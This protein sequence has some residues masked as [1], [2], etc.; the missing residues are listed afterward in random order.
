MNSLLIGTTNPAKLADYKQLLK[1]YR[2]KIISLA[3][4]KVVPPE[5]IG[6]TFEENAELKARYYYS[7]TGIPT[8]ADDGGFEIEALNGEPGVRSHRWL[9]KASD[10]DDLINEVI[11][12]MQKV[13]SNMRICRL[14]SVVAIASNLGVYTSEASVEG[15]V[16]QKPSSVRIKGFPFRSV[17]YLPNYKKYFCDLTKEELSILNHRKEALERLSDILK[18]LEKDN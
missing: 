4:L 14:R 1:K 12:R 2:F 15:Q 8:L 18:E 16:S 11:K 13:P 10:D 17:M 3:D 5:E 9:G 7:H 6:Q